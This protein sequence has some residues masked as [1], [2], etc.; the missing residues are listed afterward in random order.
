MI[1]DVPTL[2]S[3]RQYLL[4]EEVNT[5]LGKKLPFNRAWVQDSESLAEVYKQAGLEVVKNWESENYVP[6]TIL[7]R[8]TAGEVFDRIAKTATWGE[9]GKAG[10]EKLVE[11]RK[12]YVELFERVSNEE[13]GGR[14]VRD[15]HRLYI[16]VGRTPE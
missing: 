14:G 7:P 10:E 3:S 5:E 16:T 2:L 4:M 11:A 13:E 9:L 8:E 6:E 12:R 15:Y 1:I